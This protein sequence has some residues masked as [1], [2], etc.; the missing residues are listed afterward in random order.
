MLLKKL[1][2]HFDNYEKLH[3]EVNT[4]KDQLVEI[5]CQ[6]K[7]NFHFVEINDGILRGLIHRYIRRDSPY[8]DQIMCS[9]ICI[10]KSLDPEW[11]RL[12]AVKELLHI[13]DTKQ[14]TAQ[15]EAAVEKLIERLS[16]PF[17]VQHE[18][19][20]SLND[21]VYILFAL[22]ILVPKGCRAIL[23]TLYDNGHIT[24]LD[25][26][27]MAQIPERYADVVMGDWFEPFLSEFVYDQI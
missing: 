21:R 18:T 14:E 27:Q 22:A 2:D 25:V 7:I 17:E 13:T 3:I 9:D 12:V 16:L 10:A 8:G 23:R 19:K 20:S 26:A 11:R 5:G 4:V 15:S 6:D 1:F 24:L